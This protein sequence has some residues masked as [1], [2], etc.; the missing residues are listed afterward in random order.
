MIVES[1]SPFAL[2]VTMQFKKDG[3]SASKVKTR[4]G[5][6]YWE[7]NKLLIPESQPFPLIDEILIKTWGCSW[8]SALDINAR[9]FGQFPLSWWIGSNQPLLPSVGTTNG[10]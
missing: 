9:R 10:A 1:Q 7:L 5:V 3:L 4:I 2:P 6:D 8:F